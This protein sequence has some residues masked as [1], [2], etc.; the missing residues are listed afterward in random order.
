VK[1]PVWPGMSPG[2]CQ[3]ECV[4]S[5][6]DASPASKNFRPIQT[7]AESTYLPQC[8]DD[9]AAKGEAKKV[10]STRFRR[11]VRSECR[12]VSMARFNSHRLI[13]SG[14]SEAALVQKRSEDVE[15]FLL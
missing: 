7:G 1:P 4:G 14:R 8:C 15:I 3:C 6:L 12:A 13:T 2:I 10:A 5:A 11:D 9:R